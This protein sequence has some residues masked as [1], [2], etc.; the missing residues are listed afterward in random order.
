M[1]GK[2][3]DVVGNDVIGDLIFEVNQARATGVI[4]VVSKQ[5]IEDIKEKKRK[6]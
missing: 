3:L 6:L 5:E 2:T 1:L 4:K